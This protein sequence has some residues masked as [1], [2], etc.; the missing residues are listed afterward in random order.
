[1]TPICADEESQMQA[2]ARRHTTVP[3][4]PG[5]PALVEFEYR[6]RGTLA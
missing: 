3:A 2:L 4:A 6:R 5:R 1:L